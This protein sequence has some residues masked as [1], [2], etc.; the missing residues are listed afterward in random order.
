MQNDKIQNDVV[1]KRK[2]DTKANAAITERASTCVKR[3]EAPLS[4][5]SRQKAR[6][7]L[8]H[9]YL[10]KVLSYLVT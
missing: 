10:K 5:S 6:D 9:A 3:T 1:E 7:V 2:P 8:K 4:G